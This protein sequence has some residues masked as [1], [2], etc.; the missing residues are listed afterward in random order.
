[1]LID[2]ISKVFS[3]ESIVIL[4]TENVLGFERFIIKYLI[5]GLLLNDHFLLV[6]SFLK[7]ETLHGCKFLFRK[8]RWLDLF[9]LWFM[10]VISHQARLLTGKLLN[11]LPEAFKSIFISFNFLRRIFRKLFYSIISKTPFSIH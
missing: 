10:V 6:L 9:V 4:G 2:K 11:F 3:K 8:D 5:F 1:M 7:R